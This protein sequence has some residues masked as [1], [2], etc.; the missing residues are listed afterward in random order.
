VK[1]FKTRYKI[2]RQLYNL[3]LQLL[4]NSICICCFFTSNAQNCP[5]NIDFETGTFEGWTCYTGTTSAVGD[6]NV[7][8]LHSSGGPLFDRHK[9][10]SA[11]ANSGE[12]DHYGGFPVVCPNGSRYSIKLGNT[13]AGGQAEG[14][15]YTFTIPANEN[16]YSLTYHYAVVFQYPDHR[17]NEQPRM[18]IEITD[19]TDDSVISCSSFTFIAVGTSV[20]G[21]LVSP[22]SDTIEVLY[23]NWSKVSIDLSGKAGKTIR[24]FF[25]TA[26]CTFRRHFGYAY[27]DVDSE[28]GGRFAGA[29]YCP[30]DTL[31]NLTAPDGYQRYTWYDNN[32]THILGTEQI[33]TLSPPPV[34]GT[35]IAVKLD[36]YDGYGCS[37]I[38]STR[39]SNSLTVTPN[40]G[41][42]TLS[43]N[44]DPVP[45]G[46]LS[47]PGL[48]Y[49]WTPD[50]GLSNAKIANPF[51]APDTTTTYI[52]T[53]NSSGGGCRGND[54]VVVRSSIIDDSLQLTG[55][56]VF[57]ID[58]GDS[59][60]LKVHS[61]NSV[62][63]FKDNVLLNGAD[64]PTYRATSGGMYYARLK[65]AE[66]CKISTQKKAI[67]I[68]QAK[69]GITYPVEYAMINL[70]LP[71]K[72]RQI[73]ERILWNP[74][75]SLNTPESFTPIFKGALERMYTIEIRTN[76]E[77]LTVDTQLVRII[78][79][80]EIYV[81]TAFTPNGD[82]TND[83]LRPILRGI[84]ELRYFR[85]FNRLGQLVC[86][87][88]NE[89]SGWNGVFK[90]VPQRMQVVVWTLQCV[91]ADDVVYTRKGASTLL[92]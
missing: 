87:T 1:H 76:T 69:P 74:A 85:I 47:Q 36:P 62:Q 88:K 72:A 34:P 75:A 7:I 21:F 70:P 50:V 43:C 57:C 91:G 68:D 82:G 65:N 27:I 28:C 92:R 38:L 61:T 11:I 78:K 10:Y 32:L 3:L 58:N 37:T 67:V 59:A 25:K 41:R 63:W 64:Q 83:F 56:A 13:R 26:D 45:I 39:L 16:S 44:K 80:I 4:T 81:P 48:Q 17:E 79:N 51:A 35:N 19:V 18:E 6:E 23:K 14:V 77:C 55:K 60:V 29:T 40:A 31:V 73:G 8:S 54:T 52:V 9:M 42:D 22:R 66:G 53:T 71:L 86:E 15:S 46:A 49:K 33:L 2:E 20:P 89:Q 5:P 90:G 84:K 30:D 12:L 24:L